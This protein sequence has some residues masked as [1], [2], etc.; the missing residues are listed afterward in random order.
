MGGGL[1]PLNMKKE[2]M[3]VL[4]SQRRSKAERNSVLAKQGQQ[5][6]SSNP[7]VTTSSSSFGANKDLEFQRSG[8]MAETAATEMGKPSKNMSVSRLRKEIE[9]A[10][11]F[12]SQLDQNVQ[13]IE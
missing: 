10:H 4:S 13:T 1:P 5:I 7:Y 2:K 3:G 12:I 6:M 9:K 8:T 11:N